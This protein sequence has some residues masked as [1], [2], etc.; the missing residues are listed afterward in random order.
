MKT[1]WLLGNKNYSVQND[2]L[3]CHWNPEISRRKK[4]ENSLGSNQ[5]SLSS[6][7]VSDSSRVNTPPIPEELGAHD[8]FKGSQRLTIKIGESTSD[9]ASAQRNTFPPLHQHIPEKASLLELPGSVRAETETYGKEMAE[10]RFIL[11]GVV[12]EF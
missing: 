11:P 6:N 8:L 3:V 1:Y 5:Q 10:K 9:T 12:E 4:L 7:V 2:S